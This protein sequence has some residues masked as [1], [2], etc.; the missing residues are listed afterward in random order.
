MVD[1]QGREHFVPMYEAKFMRSPDSQGT[2][3]PQEF[4]FAQHQQI[5]QAHASRYSNERGRGD[6]GGRG[7]G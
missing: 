3:N 4:A 6:D 2:R 7:L 1:R 5:E